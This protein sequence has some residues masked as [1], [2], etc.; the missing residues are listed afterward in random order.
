MRKAKIEYF[1]SAYLPELSAIDLEIA[2]VLAKAEAS[3]IRRHMTQLTSLTLR[4]CEPARTMLTLFAAP[5]SFPKLREAALPE[6]LEHPAALTL[7][8]RMAKMLAL[9][10]VSSCRLSYE[11]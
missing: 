8:L 3:F 1:S 4:G 11:I 10:Y 9:E 2:F 5:L 7:Q 6:P